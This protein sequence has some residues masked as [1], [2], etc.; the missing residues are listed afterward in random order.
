[1]FVTVEETA[2]DSSNLSSKVIGFKG[3]VY[4]TLFYK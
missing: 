1:M 3:K 2:S 4:Y